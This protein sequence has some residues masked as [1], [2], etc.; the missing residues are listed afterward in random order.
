M[1]LTTTSVSIL[2]L[3]CL[4]LQALLLCLLVLAPRCGCFPQSRLQTESERAVE[5]HR[6]ASTCSKTKHPSK[7]Q[8]KLSNVNDKNAIK[9]QIFT[10]TLESCS[11][12]GLL[13]HQPE[14]NDLLLQPA[15]WP[16]PTHTLIRDSH[17]SQRTRAPSDSPEQNRHIW[18]EHLHCKLR[19]V[20]KDLRHS[21]QN[22][23]KILLQAVKMTAK[24]TTHSRCCSFFL[25]VYSLQCTEVNSALL[26]IYR[27]TKLTTYTSINFIM[28][29]LCILWFDLYLVKFRNSYKSGWLINL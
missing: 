14:L 22:P 18:T 23:S 12:W 13:H 3:Y 19:A 24:W 7:K 8:H 28:L 10:L 26:L 9:P 20:A 21:K 25:T 11:W 17:H 5:Y 16:A 2:G 1:N 4:E 15:Q 6:L 29:P 27:S